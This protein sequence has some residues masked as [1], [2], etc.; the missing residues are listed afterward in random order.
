[1]FHLLMHLEVLHL[2]MSMIASCTGL[3]LGAFAGQ[4]LPTGATSG[5]SL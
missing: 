4:L 3:M 5:H 2:S 1:M